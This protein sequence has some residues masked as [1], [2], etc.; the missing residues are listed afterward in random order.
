[1]MLRLL[2]HL[3][4]ENAA[5]IAFIDL[6]DTEY[7]AMQAGDFAALPALNARK[8]EGLVQL[9]LLDQ[10]REQQL[11]VL[12]YSADQAGGDALAASGGEAL[13]YAWQQLQQSARQAREHNHRN[14]LL[15]HTHLDFTRQALG[16]LKPGSPALYGPDG[17]HARPAGVGHRLGLG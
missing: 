11:K 1:M 6:L 13:Q 5:L 8:S 10:W 3:R 15:V 12:G 9:T 7:E 2:D 4:R 17:S 16:F 14:G